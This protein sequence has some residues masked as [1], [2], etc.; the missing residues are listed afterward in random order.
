MLAHN[1]LG[2]VG[3][4]ERFAFLGQRTGDE[5]LG[6][7]LFFPRLIEPAAQR[8][9]FFHADGVF[10]SAEEKHG[11]G[12]RSPLGLAAAGEHRLGRRREG[13]GG[14]G[15]SAGEDSTRIEGQIQHGRCTLPRGLRHRPFLL[16]FFQCFMNSAH[17]FPSLGT[18]LSES[19]NCSASLER[20][21]NASIKSNLSEFC[22]EEETEGRLRLSPRSKSRATASTMPTVTTFR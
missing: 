14:A 8:P 6:K 12:I 5:Q 16:C 22:G 17:S 4:G 9:E 15:T 7:R 18:S 2:Q 20:V 19:F 10:F 1:H 11:L 21:F 13:W 3:S